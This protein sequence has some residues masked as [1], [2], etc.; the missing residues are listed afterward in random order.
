MVT[1][2][3][4]TAFT[5]P[6]TLEVLELAQRVATPLSPPAIANRVFENAIAVVT[7]HN[8][9]RMLG[10]SSDYNKSAL[11][12]P[13]IQLAADLSDLDVMSIGSLECRAIASEQTLSLIHI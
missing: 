8:F 13:R 3:D 2:R 4:P 12:D 10:I 6:I 1:Y 5:L 9:L 11:L 7:V